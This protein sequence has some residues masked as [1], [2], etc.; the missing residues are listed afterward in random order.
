MPLPSASQIP[1][2]MKC[3]ASAVY[4]RTDSLVEAAETGHDIHDY[5]R[6]LASMPRDEALAKVPEASRSRCE[7]IDLSALPIGPGWE[8]EVALAY[9]V[10]TET[11]RFIGHDIGRKYGPRQSPSE[12]FLTL[13]VAGVVGPVAFATDYK[14]GAGF[15]E[16]PASNWQVKSG[17]LAMTRWKGLEAARGAIIRLLADGPPVVLTADFDALELDIIA[18][19]LRELYRRIERP[20]GVVPVMGAHCRYCPAFESCPA[21]GKL[22]ARMARSPEQ[23]EHDV[24]DML[25]PE[26]AARAY[27]RL[28]AVDAVMKRMWAAVFAYA[29]EHPI[30]LENGEVFGETVVEKEVLDAEVVRRVLEEMHGR[31][32]ADV[33]CDFETSKTA[34]EKALRPIYEARKKL[35][36]GTTLKALKE[37]VYA[38]VREEGGVHLVRRVEVK[39]HRP[40][41]P[42]LERAPEGES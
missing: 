13:D 15:V 17:V 39:A 5:L 21:Q 2:A 6:N 26:T 16:G 18:S 11:V 41:V 20:E 27:V 14:S 22:I 8:A 38:R 34:V 9:D 24:K 25:T 7:D 32:V 42:T 35:E 40:D 1:L 29:K 30:P 12:M 31:E 33:A 37:A 4:P 10:E 3:A 19:E 36:K 28:K 23:L